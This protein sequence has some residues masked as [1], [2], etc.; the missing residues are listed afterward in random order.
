M[1]AMTTSSSIK[2]KPRDDGSIR[3]VEDAGADDAEA[4]DAGADDAEADDAE[5]DDA[6][7]DDAG[8]DDAEADDAEADDAGADDAGADDAGADDAGAEAVPFPPLLRGGRGGVGTHAS[9][10]ANGASLRFLGQR[11]PR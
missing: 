7:A 2:V 11:R 8:A 9:T 1:I 5:A 6:E 10:G 4:D 3:C